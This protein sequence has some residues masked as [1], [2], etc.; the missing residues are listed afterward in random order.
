MYSYKDGYINP[1]RVLDFYND[2]K[3]DSEIIEECMKFASGFQPRTVIFD[4]KDWLI[5]RAI[6]LP[7][8]TTVIVDGVKIK[9]KDL[10]F[11]AIFRGDN[12]EIDPKNPN[13][14]PLK[15]HP[16]SNIRIL[17]KNGAILE[18]PDVLPRMMHPT[19]GEEQ[20]MV[21]DYWGWRNFQVTL[22]RCTNFELA[23]FTYKKPRSWAN[24]FDRCSYGYIHDLD[25]VSEVKNGDGVNLRLGCHHITIENI[26]GHTS[27][28]LIALNTTTIGTTYPC[29]RYVYPLDPSSYL[30]NEGEDIRERDIHD[31]TVSNVYSSTSLYSHA[32]ALLS[33]HGHQIYNVYIN[34]VIDGNPISESKRLAIIGSYKGYGSGYNPG[35]MHDIKINH[36]VSNSSKH[37]IVFNDPVKN[38]W[39]NNVI[40]NRPDGDVLFTVDPEGITMTNCK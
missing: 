15:I 32:I 24:S 2:M 39:I 8:N 36:I 22:S 4:G 33:R 37:A 10:M 28:D 30:I 23:G 40:Q 19:M 34:N 5:D 11:D 31:I 25:I 1:V 35:D 13:G 38:V 7:S 27:D 12:F 9:Q 16:I 6:L 20:V 14:F 3:T 21:G 18:G 17:G 29:S 26:K